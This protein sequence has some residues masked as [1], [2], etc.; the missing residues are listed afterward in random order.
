MLTDGGS[1]L[2]TAQF[3]TTVDHS[4][5]SATATLSASAL[6]LPGGGTFRIRSCIWYKA[7]A[8]APRS[9]CE[10]SQV[11]GDLA[12][13][14]RGVTAPQAQMQI[15]RPGAGQPAGTTAATVLIDQLQRSGGWS[16]L[17]S[18]WPTE[19]MRVAGLAVPAVGQTSGESLGSQGVAVDGVR[20]G[21]INTFAQDSICRETEAPETSPARGSV[22]A[23]GPLAFAYEVQQ[24][25]GRPRGTILILHGGGWHVIG[26]GALAST[27]GE[28]DRWLSRGWRTV[29]ASYRGCS[30][31]SDDVVT[32]FDRVQEVYGGS[33][34]VCASG[35][36]AG[37]HL[38][39]LLA[40]V[41]SRLACVVAQAGP[42]DLTALAGQ[43]APDPA[44]R[45]SHAGPR[46]VANMAVAAFGDDRLAALSPTRQAVGARVL[47]AIGASDTAIPWQ[48]AT[49]FAAAQRARDREAYVDTLQLASG[50]IYWI[51]A[52]VSQE[53]L[54]ELSARE[55]ALVA[56]LT[57]TTLRT[58]SSVRAAALKRRGL[59]V[60]YSCPSACKIRVRI[61]R[62]ARSIALARV[63]RASFGA[64]RMIVRLSARERRQ[65]ARG[66]LRLVA[67]LRAEG[68]AKRVRRSIKLR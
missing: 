28:A 37:A 19:G 68:A 1:S 30:S 67:E 11:T 14:L 32:L 12:S 45:V 13:R 54:N 63:R 16:S 60:S 7:A 42:A 2:G 33:R 41:R 53:G 56:P 49:G 43:A 66:T 46:R 35:Q 62:G 39:L 9:V 4:G 26:R 8:V 59:P 52:L 64:G 29:N 17:A 50:S 24:P 31:S 10:S 44:G 22:D 47:I 27:R 21:G 36:S 6:K 65:L 3:Q 34:P 20:P 51:H 58:P 57:T 18:S 38:A 55:E 48:Q 25:A 40:A 5:A 61:R 15:D 23:L